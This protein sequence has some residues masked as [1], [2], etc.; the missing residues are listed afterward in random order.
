MIGQGS[1][2]YILYWDAFERL[3][4]NSEDLKSFQGSLVGFSGEPVKVNGYVTLK[5]T[6][7]ASENVRQ[8]NVRY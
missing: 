6:F 4:L 5:N 7:G 1:S 3:F 8:V 2:P